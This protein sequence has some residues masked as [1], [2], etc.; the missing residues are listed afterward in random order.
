MGKEGCI[1]IETALDCMGV[2]SSLVLGSL[3]VD[4]KLHLH[5]A[6]FNIK[7]VICAQR[8]NTALPKRE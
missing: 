3:P 4:H 7:D 1:D 8:F 5:T 6:W 2:S